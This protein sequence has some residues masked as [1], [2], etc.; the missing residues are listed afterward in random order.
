MTP[1]PRSRPDTGLAFV[2]P[3][4]HETGVAFAWI[5]EDEDEA[6]G[7]ELVLQRAGVD[8]RF[9][10]DAQGWVLR[11]ADQALQRAQVLHGRIA[12]HYVRGE[13]RSLA[14]RLDA[15]ERLTRHTLYGAAIAVLWAVFAFA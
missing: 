7:V 9:E 13:D 2:P 3:R 6:A 14:L 1:R 10:P 11:G 12:Q 8:A 5:C 4:R 15:R